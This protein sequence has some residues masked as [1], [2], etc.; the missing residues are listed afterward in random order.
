MVHFV[1]V[2]STR[3]AGAI[4]TTI[5]VE[6]NYLCQTCQ[7]NET[8]YNNYTLNPEIE[9]PNQVGKQRYPKPYPPST[10]GANAPRLT[11][12]ELSVDVDSVN[13]NKPDKTGLLNTGC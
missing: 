2:I 4:S 1:K 6:I 12:S 10:T 5:N 11:A 9:T 7:P 8:N 13:S 3:T